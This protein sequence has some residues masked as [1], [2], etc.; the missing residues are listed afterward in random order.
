MT[1]HN[2]LKSEIEKLIL[3]KT[4]ST[5]EI[6]KSITE[7]LQK[8][9]EKYTW[10]GFYHMNDTNRTLHLGQYTGKET[11]HTIIPYGKGICG[12]VAVSGS[13][14]IAEDV[15]EESNYIAC[16]VDV[17][18]EIVVPIYYNDRLVAQLDVDSRRVNAFDEDDRKM[19]EE[20]CALIGDNL[21]SEMVF[22]N[23]EV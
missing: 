9:T 11:D 6:L 12:Q 3:D 19:L 8:D 2:E 17:R 22:E 5:T 13:T 1:S 18:S 21:G 14:Y 16:S 23:K 4:R 7:H 10:V 20:I 15:T